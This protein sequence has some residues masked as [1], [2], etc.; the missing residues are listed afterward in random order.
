MFR[1]LL[2]K[3]IREHLMTFRFGAALLT[4]FVLVVISVWVLGDDFQ[5]RRDAFNLAAED[6]A[7]NDMQVVVPSQIRPTVHRT[8][9]VL[10]VFAQGEDRRFGNTV[11]VQR[12]EV[13][14]RAEGSF[15]D[16]MLLAAEP[17]LDLYTIFALVVSLFGIL[18][19][20]DA[21]SGERERGTLKIQCSAGAGRASILAAKLLG[22]IICLAIPFV[23]SFLSG[24]LLLSLFLGVCL[25]GVP[26]SAVA[27]ILLAGL[28]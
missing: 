28:V 13:P 17:A 8:P 15:T 26:W 16:N 7:R 22:G 23:F 3:E 11:L 9:S 14:R 1:V 4:T 6:S 5:R 10:S 12:W 20:Y 25:T 24:L 21:V 2:W 19:S 18:F 27:I